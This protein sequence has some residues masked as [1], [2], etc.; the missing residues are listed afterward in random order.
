M[1]DRAKL[2]ERLF[3]AFNRRDLDALLGLCNEDVEFHAA[4]ADF[5]DRGEPYRGRQGMRDYFDD[6]DRIWE[7]LL[8]TPRQIVP[9]DDGVV[10]YG[11]VF[12]RGRELGIRDLPIAWR[13][14]VRD[15]RFTWGKVYLDPEQVLEA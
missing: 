1:E 7:E 3:D 4:T 5:A 10:V 2:V 15:G 6:V 13:W 11:Q 8:I 12:A 9:I 14:M